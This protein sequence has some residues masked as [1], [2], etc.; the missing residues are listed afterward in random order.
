MNE[1]AAIPK[2][3]TR[4]NDHDIKIIWSDD[5]ESI[6]VARDLRLRCQCAQCVEEMTGRK[7][8]DPITVP[9]DVKPNEIKLVGRYAIQIWWSDGHGSGIFPFVFLRNLDEQMKELAAKKFE[10]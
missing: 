10:I 4:A 9:L 3:V 8:L 6:F 5:C 1:K 2:E 7:L